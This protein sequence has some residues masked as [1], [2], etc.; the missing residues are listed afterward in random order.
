M[1]QI[2]Y[3]RSGG[4]KFKDKCTKT[5]FR[6]FKT[7]VLNGVGQFGGDV[8]AEVHTQQMLVFKHEL[9]RESYQYTVLKDDGTTKTT[10][11]AWDDAQD[12]KL[13]QTN[14]AID[15]RNEFNSMQRALLW[16]AITEAVTD[17]VRV[18]MMNNFAESFEAARTIN[19][20]AAY[21]QILEQVC[22]SLA[23]DVV[24]TLREQLYQ[25]KHNWKGK[26]HIDKYIERLTKL[27]KQLEEAGDVLTD[28]DRV[29][30]LTKSVDE[31]F[32][33]PYVT[34][35]YAYSKGHQSYPKWTDITK[36]M[37]TLWNNLK[38]NKSLE[39]GKRGRSDSESSSPSSSDSGDSDSGRKKRKRK[40]S[41]K[42]KEKKDKPSEQGAVQRLAKMEMQVAQMQKAW[43]NKAKNMAEPSAAKKAL[44]EK[45]AA[46]LCYRCG[47]KG[48][49]STKC[50]KP[51]KCGDCGSEY[52]MTQYCQI[53][54][55]N[56]AKRNARNGKTLENKM[57]RM[58][59]AVDDAGVSTRSVAI[60]T[61][62]EPGSFFAPLTA[63]TDVAPVL[64][65]HLSTE[66][67]LMNGLTASRDEPERNN[68]RLVLLR[69]RGGQED[70]DDDDD[71]ANSRA[72]SPLQ[73]C[74]SCGGSRRR[75]DRCRGRHH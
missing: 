10:T 39:D 56:K 29:Y 5:G 15:R 12:A 30:K 26:E 62:A 21:M 37:S 46:A 73:C 50:T 3:A 53:I 55:D 66:N 63:A 69:L 40:R 65:D 60:A 74:G 54:K 43:S 31:T 45:I 19:N 44:R 6:K 41:R 38:D 57:I 24:E 16:I 36:L 47:K 32:W 51:C 11:H 72:P 7:G 22:Q 1:S 35:A 75:Y 52:H 4:Y 20:V 28:A 48:H 71:A 68:L 8:S 59:L 17:T 18:K 9:P 2:R 33:A 34:D 13:L 58:T 67:R 42:N 64:G 14:L 70:S 61:P 23:T 27:F 25:T 49:F